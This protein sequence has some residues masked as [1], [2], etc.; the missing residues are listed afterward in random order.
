MC[1]GTRS[2]LKTE[3]VTEDRAF[4]V[5]MLLHIRYWYTGAL[6]RVT[7]MCLDSARGGNVFDLI[8]TTAVKNRQVARFANAELDKMANTGL[9]HLTL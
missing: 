2:C 8:D 3:V 1:K 9:F 7:F 4:P 6:G 5:Y